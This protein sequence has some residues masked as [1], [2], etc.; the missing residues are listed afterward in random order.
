M[1]KILVLAWLAM[2]SV[3]VQA[4]QRIV[5]LNAQGIGYSGSPQFLAVLDEANSMQKKYQF[6]PEFKIGG[7]ES[8]ALREVKSK[9]NTYI[10]TVVTTH[11][12]AA[13]RGLI[14]LDDYVPLYSIGD[15]CWSLAANF[16][17]EKSGLNSLNGADAPK[18]IVVGAP[19][20]GGA[21]HLTALEIG[22]K[23]K[24]P[25]RFIFYK[26]NS[27]A[28]IAM[29]QGDINVTM[30]RV[31]VYQDYKSKF[32]NIS[33][34]ASSCG[35]RHPDAP[36][37]KTLAEQKIIVPPIFNV[38]VASKDMDASRRKEIK[39]IFRQAT[40]NIG[41]KKLPALGDHWPAVFQNRDDEEYYYSM[42]K[43]HQELR[44][45]WNSEVDKFR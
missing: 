32:P 3:V 29:L 6:V 4:Q 18:E 20:L 45:K 23:Y 8:V 19:A 22:E 21:L 27:E 43:R 28:V 42:V 13:D 41:T 37:V 10:S 44:K 15:A 14:S 16:G 31:R 39:D 38:I 36:H 5:V 9:P 7:F 33:I 1:I 40:L 17:D 30:D 34:L 35:Q 25:V 11:L 12:E 24:K 2:M 26:T